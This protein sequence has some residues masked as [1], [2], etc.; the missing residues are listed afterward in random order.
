MSKYRLYDIAKELNITNKE[1]LDRLPELGIE[2]KSHSSSVGESD[3]IKVKESILSKSKGA[4]SSLPRPETASKPV[5]KESKPEPVSDLPASDL[6]NTSDPDQ[7]KRRRR[8][9]KEE[10]AEE[11]S[12]LAAPGDSSETKPET[13]AEVSPEQRPRPAPRPLPEGVT[14]DEQGRLRR[15]DGTIIQPRP[16]PEG[17]TRDAQG[18]LVRPDGTIIPPRPLPEGVTRDAQGRLVRPDGTIIPPRPLPEGVTRDAQGRLVRPDGTV[19]P[20]RP[21][22]L[23]EGVTR[24]AQG[25]LV[26]PDGTIIPP[27]PLPEGVTRDAQGRLVRPDGTII[28]PR[29][30]PLPEGFTRDAQGRVI[31]PD[32]TLAPPRPRPGQEGGQRPP[33]PAGSQGY[34]GGSRPPYNPSADGQRRPR[35]EGQRYEGQ[36]P[37]GNFRD[38]GSRDGGPRPGGQGRDGG[39]APGQFG[40]RRGPGGPRP[41]GMQPRPGQAQGAGGGRFSRPGASGHDKAAKPAQ[42]P[43]KSERMQNLES[44]KTWDKKDRPILDRENKNTRGVKGAKPVPKTVPRTPKAAPISLEPR[45]III[46]SILTVKALAEKM[47]ISGAELVKAFI[48]QGN[49][50]GINNE[51]PYSAA[52]EIALNYNIIAEEFVEADIFE[53]AFGEAPEDE[54]L[55]LPRP[56]VVVV[57]GHVD[58]GKTSLLDA[59]RQANVTKGEAGGIT[60]HIGAYTVSINDKPI[61]FLDTPGHEAFTAMRMRGAQVTDVAVLVVAADDGV[62]PQTI[63]AISH[64]KAAGVEIIVAINKIDKP[65]ANPDKVKQELT[66]HELVVEDYGGTTPSVP[67]SAKTLAGIDSLLEMIILVS[68]MKELKANPNKQA[69]GV[70]LEALLDKGKGAVARVLV[71]EGTLNIGDPIVSGA[72]F[73]KVRA[74]IDDKGKRVKKA[75][76][77]MPVEILG[78]PG[79]PGAGD[80]FYVAANDKQARSVAESYY[81]RGRVEFNKAQNQKV[82]LDDLFNQIQAGKVK[83][84]N[85]IIKAD[86]QGSVEALRQSLD[87]LNSEEVRI[88]TILGSVGAITESDVSLASASNAIIIGFNVRPEAAA[89]TVAEEQSVDIRLYRVIYNAIEDIQ[90]A[91]KGLLDPVFEEKILG[92]AEIRQLFKASG[93]GTIGGSYILDGKFIRNASVRIIRDSIVVYEG[94]LDSLRRFKDDVREVNSGYECGLVFERFNDIKTGDIVEAYVMEEIKR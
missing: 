31:R 21:R 24:D 58:H 49:M 47:A 57:M 94:A 53:D 72:T 76:P 92:K 90:Q 52:A 25:R 18:R 78:L 15:P 17:V 59:I 42:A 64:A 5:S 60:Q 27:R 33:R 67:V 16:L 28:P 54:S 20:P 29:P 61:T 51:I 1:L 88:K 56:P 10:G 80:M 70:V 82:S 32:G 87:K 66:S 38:G 86:V 8:K 41:G 30:R 62:M 65:G 55:K 37:G 36:R 7:P 91:M 6:N 71:Q 69:R 75:G 43:D 93:I 34:Q 74:M 35:P 3:Y 11:L 45:T 44:R 39:R 13:K 40:D 73:G 63:E 22:P 68:E 81:A 89:K 23:P 14:R 85:I 46:P 84:L 9:P 50:I 83:D 19:I 2:A 48:K 79:V 12:P 77:S 4:A 26:R